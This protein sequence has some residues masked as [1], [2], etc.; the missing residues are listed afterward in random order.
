MS[1]MRR[2]MLIGVAAVI[3]TA[4][5]AVAWA[6]LLA[7]DWPGAWLPINATASGMLKQGGRGWIQGSVQKG[8]AWVQGPV[9]V[10]NG[11]F[12]RWNSAHTQRL[13]QTIGTR[14]LY[15]STLHAGS[16]WWGMR[17]NGSIW[18]NGSVEGNVSA[19]GAGR[20]TVSG[21]QHIWAAG[22]PLSITI[23]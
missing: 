23:K 4:V 13:F 1:V 12:V 22:D 15:V 20:Y 21:R 16:A 3:L 11:R 17:L 9:T 18:I 8:S 6:G 7:S 10:A 14:L 5:P 19:V 2:G